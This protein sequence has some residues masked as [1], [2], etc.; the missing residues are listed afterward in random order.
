MLVFLFLIK[1]IVNFVQSPL[2][3][4]GKI[5]SLSGERRTTVLIRCLL[6]V[7]LSDSYNDRFSKQI[8]EFHIQTDG[9][10]TKF[11]IFVSKPVAHDR[12]KD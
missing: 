3:S 2:S 5:A 10:P 8:C 4:K 7:A 11:I 6:N 1:H 9:L 12:S